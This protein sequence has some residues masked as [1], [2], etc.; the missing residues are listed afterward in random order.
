MHLSLQLL[1]LTM[2][3]LCPFTNSTSLCRQL[4]QVDYL[5]TLHV[6]WTLELKLPQWCLCLNPWR[7]VVMS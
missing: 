3:F 5:E 6:S 2:C 7:S 4:A 1:F